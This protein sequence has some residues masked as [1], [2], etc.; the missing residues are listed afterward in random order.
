VTKRDAAIAAIA[1]GDVYICFV[2]KFHGEL[3]D[4]PEAA[5]VRYEFTKS[6]A[7]RTGAFRNKKAPA[8]GASMPSK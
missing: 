7:V 1:S 2:N 4:L 3:P 6:R 8:C 5:G